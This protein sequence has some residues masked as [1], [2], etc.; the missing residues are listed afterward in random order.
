MPNILI[1]ETKLKS[2]SAPALAMQYLKH[3]KRRRIL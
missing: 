1:A 3:V 2:F